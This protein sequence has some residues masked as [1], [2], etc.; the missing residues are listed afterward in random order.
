M[1]KATK[2]PSGNWRCKAYY[3]DEYGERKSKSFTAET[4]NAAELAAREFVEDRKHHAKPENKTL[5]ELADLYIET[6]FLSPST[7]RGY[8][9]IRNNAL[10]SIINMRVGLLTEDIYQKA[11][12]EYAEG[13]SPKTVLSAHVFFNKILNKYGITVGNSAS[14]PQKEDPDIQIP[15]IEE[16]QTFMEKIKGTRLYLYCLFSVCLGLRKSE[17]IGLQWEDIDLENR[18]ISI[19]HA[20]VRGEGGEYVL[21][22]TKTKKG[23]RTL[24][25][26]QVLMDALE[27]IEDKSGFVIKEPAKG[28]ESLYQRQSKRLDFPYNFHALRHYYASIMLMHGIPNRYAKEKMGH[29]SEDMLKRVYQHTFKNVTDQHDKTLDTFFT[30]MFKENK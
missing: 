11:L 30:T 7:V 19:N 13:R 29:A 23:K 5:G 12:G 3:T 14:L 16:M 20:K 9:S 22:A 2:L 26:P 21:K 28:M 18:K 27:E 24:H 25:I 6:Q 1:A 8:K 15:S 17:T 4:K 10:Q